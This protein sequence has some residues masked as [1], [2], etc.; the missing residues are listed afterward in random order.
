[1]IVPMAAIMAY[2]HSKDAAQ[3][4]GK[5]DKMTE[6]RARAEMDAMALIDKIRMSGEDG[7]FIW[8]L[9]LGYSQGL[10]ARSIMEALRMNPMAA[11]MPTM[12]EKA[13]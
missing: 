6:E 3:G 9:T 13:V 12:N 1:M 5:E 7:K 11:M 8:G 2:I 10:Q 4:G